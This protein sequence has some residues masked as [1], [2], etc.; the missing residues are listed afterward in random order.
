MQATLVLD[1]EE[2]SHKTASILYQTK[3]EEE[4][5]RVPP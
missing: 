5:E 2:W 1:R 4:E 3:E